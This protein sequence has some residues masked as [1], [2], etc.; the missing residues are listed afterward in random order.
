MKRIITYGITLMLSTM[1]A[2]SIGRANVPAK[3]TTEHNPYPLSS[4]V[5]S[6][7]NDKITVETINGMLWTFI[8]DK[9]EDWYV[10]DICALLIDDNGTPDYIYDDIIVKARYSGFI[11]EGGK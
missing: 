7:H 9:S 2:F 5:K 3:N 1:T 4:I 10:N 8:D 6:I 11:K